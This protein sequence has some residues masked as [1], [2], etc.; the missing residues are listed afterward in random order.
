M[1]RVRNTKLILWL[2]TGFAVAVAINRF[3]FGLGA[4]TNLNDEVPWGFWIGFKLG[5]VALSA[6]GFVI[7]AIFYMMKREKFHPLVKVAIL[8]AFLGY[9]SFIISLLFDLGLPWN[10][11]HM[12]IYWNPHSPLFEVGWCVML[13]TSVLILEFSPVPLEKYSR[14]ANVRNF[15]MKFRFPLVL[16]GIMLSTLHQSSLGSLFLIMPRRLYALWFSHII[17]VQFFISAI[18]G[19]LV[20]LAFETLALNWMYRRKI[21]TSIVSQ[22]CK[23]SAW[24]LGIYFIVKMTDL[25]IAGKLGMIFNGNRLSN[26]FILEVLISI[27][28]PVIMF[29]VPKFY[30]NTKVQ[31][32]GSI[33]AI[34]GITMNRVD[35][36]G[37]AM[38]GATS[39]YIPSWMEV[40]MS[41]GILSTA[42]LIFLFVIENFHV[43]DIQPKEPESLPYTPPSFDY[44]SRSWLGTP[45]VSSITK[46]SLVFVVS[47]AFGMFLMPGKHLHSK[48]IVNIPVTRASGMDTLYINGNRDDQLV[49]FPHQAHINWIKAHKVSFINKDVFDNTVINGNDSCETCHHLT[50]PGEKL[51]ACSE[52]HSS[53]Y[54]QVDFFRHDWHKTNQRANLKCDDCHKA[55]VY[56]NAQSAKNCTDCHAT[57]KFSAN[58]YVSEKEYYILSYTDA[59]HRL[60]VSCHTAESKNL[61]DK[62]N[63][64]QCST[65]HKTELPENITAG[66]N[67]KVDLPHFNNV[68]LPDVKFEN[69]KK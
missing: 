21:E 44:S 17:P 26:L 11:W 29:S 56:R 33:I 9:S 67:W 12:I 63:L 51:S 7:A 2:I 61:K 59:L 20:M 15:L 46:Y 40:V 16:L 22:L 60:C 32:I 45:D 43:W 53:M 34:T 41:F 5:W 30:R 57:Y 69:T 48:G 4:T 64:A 31:W 19:G 66:L 35:V 23:I 6:G 49:K 10:I 39:W 36:G 25:A 54:T 18:A 24:T 28:I 50:M 8:T 42:A 1:N 37:Y 47:F 58:K 52:C 55:G 62:P 27:I 38:L 13:Y 14:Y 3:L 68:I 65:C